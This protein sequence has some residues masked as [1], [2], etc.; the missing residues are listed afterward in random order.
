MFNR[1]LILFLILLLAPVAMVVARLAHLQVFQGEYY[2]ELADNALVRPKRFI[3]A[4]RGRIVDRY[5]KVLAADEPSWDICIHYGALSRDP[6]Y[7]RNIAAEWRQKGLLPAPIEA[8]RRQQRQLDQDA[9]LQK[10]DESYARVA[11]LTDRSPDEIGR[12]RDYILDRVANV[13]KALLR[14]RGYYVEPEEFRM[15]HPLVRDLDDT[16]AVR[17]RLALAPLGWLTVQASTRRRYDE[18]TA[19][20]GHLIGRLGQV[21]AEIREQDPY[22]D[23]PTRRYLPW[24]NHGISGAERL[25]EHLVRGSRGTIESDIDGEEVDRTP[26]VDGRDAVLTIDSELQA[27][28]YG[29]VAKAIAS[30]P[31]SCGGAAVVIHIPTRQIL[32]LVSYPSFDPN[33]FARDFPKLIE[34]TR[35]RPTLFRAI[36]AVYPPGSVAKPMTLAT[37]LAL[38]LIT[39]ETRLH[40]HGYLHK[41]DGRFQCWI[42]R[43][44]QGSHDATYTNGLDAEEALQVSCNCYFYQL[45]EII[46]G[47]RLCQWFHQFWIGPPAPPGTY[48]GTG[49]IEER[50]GIIP[51]A[52]WLYEKRRRSMTVG[53][54]RN[55]AIGQGELGLTPLHVANGMA[56]IASGQ[57]MWPTVVANDG[58]ERPAW[59]LPLTSRQ[60]KAVRRGLYRVVNN[61]HGTAYG[62]ARMDEITLAGKTGSAQCT[63][64]ALDHQ[65]TVEYPDGRREKINARQ[66][67]EVEKIL[68]KTPGAKIISSHPGK[69]WPDKSD[70]LAHGWFATYAPGGPG[71]QPQIAL[72]VLVEFGENGGKR[73]APIAKEIIRALIESPHKY[74]EPSTPIEDTE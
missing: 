64:L 37:G 58:R 48:A 27:R 44:H 63:R 45:G 20:M 42:Y 5:G 60:W 24:E 17:A 33:L 73:A 70:H 51:T 1:R 12:Q 65:Y 62:Q 56:T 69:L 31:L 72:S 25:C 2:Q 8:D 28:I 52:A 19:S 54:S 43:M 57:F 50:E 46:R 47:D 55:F 16:T 13:Q 10:I 34:D 49:L 59:V 11:Q 66:K 38:N 15:S 9:I 53:D 36:A 30:Y 7:I 67:Q 4:V 35:L 21:S 39:P 29:I 40:C 14:R 26:P 68:E 71:D 41:P 74:L 61:K 6:G 22:R 32:A 18:V 3:P 23:D